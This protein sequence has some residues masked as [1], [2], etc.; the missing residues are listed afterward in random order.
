MITLFQDILRQTMERI[1]AQFIA[2]APRL[3]V[4]ILVLVIA[5]VIAK[6]VRW[7]IS[8]IFKGTA[9]DRFLRQSGLATMLGQSG[10]RMRA[11]EIVAGAAY[12]IILLAGLATGISAFDTQI[13]T[14]ITQ[15]IV[16]L[17]PKLLAA[18]AILIAGFWL[19]QYLARHLLVWSVNEGIP[20]GRRL[21]QA[22]R[23]LVIF[24][25]AAAAA[26]YLGFA[27]N[28]FLA[29]F[30]L[31]VGGIVLAASI[32]LGSYGKEI[33]HRYLQEKPEPGHEKEDMPVW[34]HL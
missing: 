28:V 15:T 17:S 9:F 6:L 27:R 11:V 10:G 2:Y 5:Y 33:L 3:L 23:I 29:A 24:V 8:R 7:L 22:L 21:A 19:G 13:T 25:A 30:I 26:D 16:F 18:G 20:A 4:G 1:S 32:A 12:W 31:V 34:R 14:Q